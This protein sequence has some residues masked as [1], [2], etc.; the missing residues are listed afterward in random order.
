MQEGDIALELFRRG[1]IRFGDFVLTSGLRSPFYIDLRRLW[2]HPDLAKAVVEALTRRLDLDRFD[3][4]VG[5]AT[6]GIPLA[7]Y[8]S[9]ATGKP[10]GYV[11][12][13]RKEHGTRSQVEG[14]AAGRRVAV[15]DDVATTGGSIIAAAH[16]L[17]S[18]GAEPVLAVVIVDREQGAEENLKRENIEMVSL[19]K[20]SKIFEKLLRAGAIDEETYRKCV[21]HIKSSRIIMGQQQ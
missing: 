15:V 21:E 9:Y 6:A 7:A 4:F 2:S 17:R 8:L 1:M 10:M 5:V 13:E 19:F 12:I 18:A 16:A 3:M 20:A 11:R 14:E